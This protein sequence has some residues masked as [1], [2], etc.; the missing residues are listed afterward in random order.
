MRR[1]LET[2]YR[3]IFVLPG[4]PFIVEALVKAGTSSS[5][6]ELGWTRLQARGL[7]MKDFICQAESVSLAS[8]PQGYLLRGGPLQRGRQL[9]GFISMALGSD[10]SL[11]KP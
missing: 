2:V 9:R 10:T 1:T 7:C 8:Q 6:R 11:V 3:E 5:L 4:T